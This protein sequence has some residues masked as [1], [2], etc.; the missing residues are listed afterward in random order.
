MSV[1]PG[2]CVSDGVRAGSGKRQE[3][4]AGAGRPGPHRRGSAGDSQAA[5]TLGGEEKSNMFGLYVQ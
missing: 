4:G 3:R 2:T 5:L 1:A